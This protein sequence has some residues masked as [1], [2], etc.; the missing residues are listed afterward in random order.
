MENQTSARGLVLFRV[1]E[2]GAL[3]SAL[4]RLCV[5]YFSSYIEFWGM[6]VFCDV[7]AIRCY[8]LTIEFVVFPHI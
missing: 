1:C 4:E 3:A 6:F 8:K 2:S 5:A 7:Q